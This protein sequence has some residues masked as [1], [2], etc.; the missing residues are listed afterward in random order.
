[1]GGTTVSLMS[2]T[3]LEYSHLSSSTST[4]LIIRPAITTGRFYS[5]YLWVRVHEKNLQTSGQTIVFGLYNTY[6]SKEDPREFSESSAFASIT[7][8]SG[9]T[10][11]ALLSS[12]VATNPGPYLKFSLTISQPAGGGG[13]ILY[14][15]V[16]AGLVLREQ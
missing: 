3:R 11:P 1:M 12:S 5:V 2:K 14:A 4:S 13:T 8:T 10:A 16:S 9:T 6:P 7:M 15:Q